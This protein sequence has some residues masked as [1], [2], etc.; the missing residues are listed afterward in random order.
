MFCKM[1]IKCFLLLLILFN[2]NI[3]Y[4]EENFGF[5]L[6]CYGGCNDGQIDYNNNLMLELTIKN[7]YNYW[8]YIGKERELGT[9]FSIEMENINLKT[10]GEIEYFNSY[11]DREIFIK[12]KSEIKIYIPFNDYNNIENN[13]RLGD[14][15]I[16]PILKLKK[17]QLY[18]NPFDSSKV[19]LNQNNIP[20]INS[21]I[22]GNVLKFTTVK[23]EIEV[24][25]KKSI[26]IP[27]G[28]LE[29]PVVLYLGFPLLVGL[30]LIYFNKRGS[31]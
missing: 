8:I 15:E 23:P 2:T 30:I 3:A 27:D 31:K 17:F 1:K 24:T 5:S 14:W 20:P 26:K 22:V 13:N 10:E 21:E 29:N 12:P 11:L 16:K 9:E 25:G 18:A 6:D 7:N 28:L 19:S 4:A